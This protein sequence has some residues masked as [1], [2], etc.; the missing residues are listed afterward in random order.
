MYMNNNEEQQLIELIHESLI[1]EKVM[2][3]FFSRWR[4]G[5]TWKGSRLSGKETGVIRKYIEELEIVYRA[6]GQLNNSH[7]RKSKLIRGNLLRAIRDLEDL[8]ISIETGRSEKDIDNRYP[9]DENKL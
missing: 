8:L 1:E 6:I 7:P 5:R 4:K 2:D 3:W 9:V